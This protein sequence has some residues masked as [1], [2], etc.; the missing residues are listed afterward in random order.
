[1]K[2]LIEIEYKDG[3]M[4][5]TNKKTNKSKEVSNYAWLMP[6]FFTNKI[7]DLLETDYKKREL[8]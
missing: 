8:N 7:K 6:E 4:I 2:D 5:I 1:M 3:Y